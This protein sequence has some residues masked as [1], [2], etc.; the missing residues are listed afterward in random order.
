MIAT[1]TTVFGSV[2][3]A[4]RR[5]WPPDD[6][7]SRAR[8]SRDKTAEPSLCADIHLREEKARGGAVFPGRRL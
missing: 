2:W 5:Q 3:F 8:C 6:A 1:G 7:S 4:V